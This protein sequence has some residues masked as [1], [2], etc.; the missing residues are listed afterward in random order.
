MAFGANGDVME[1]VQINAAAT[2]FAAGISDLDM[3]VRRIFPLGRLLQ[4]IKSNEMALI[5]PQLWDDP[6]EDPTALCMLDGTELVPSKGQRQLA[7]YL[8]PAWAQCWSLNPGSD[9]LLRAY[10]RVRLDPKS[11]RNMDR[12]NEGVIVNTTV[13]RLLSAAE[14]WHADGSDGHVVVGRVEYL[15]DEL[16]WQRIVNACNGE[17]GPRFFCTVQG[18]ANSLL[19]KREYFGHEQEVRLLLIDRSWRQDEPPP[20]V[21]FVNID[22]NTL[23]TSISFDPRLELFELNERDAELRD[24]GYKGEIVR[25]RNYEKVLSQLMMTRDWPDP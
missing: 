2:R 3:P 21:R 11:R 7:D 9:T 25:D 13:R 23:F 19:W 24:A 20:T 14:R 15:G 10:S 12:D 22:P 5:A 1:L 17:H 16:I 6:R 4:A 18:R 8:A